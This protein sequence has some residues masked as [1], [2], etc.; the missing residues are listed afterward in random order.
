[1]GDLDAR[2]L[3]AQLP[4]S[5]GVVLNL[6][7]QLV[8][9]VCCE[10]LNPNQISNQASTTVVKFLSYKNTES[11]VEACPIAKHISKSDDVPFRC[12]VCANTVPLMRWAGVYG[13]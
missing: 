11:G 4:N 8:L 6:R 10:G 7:N 5:F 13:N 12:I 3:L 1:M 9:N 2:Q